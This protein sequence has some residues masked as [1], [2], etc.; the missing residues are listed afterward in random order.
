[1]KKLVILLGITSVGLPIL[2]YILTKKHY[3]KLAKT[4]VEAAINA[5]S[6]EV[7]SFIDNSS[8]KQENQAEEPAEINKED[9]LPI[10]DKK[11]ELTD[12]VSRY[13]KIDYSS[14]FKPGTETQKEKTEDIQPE[15]MPKGS[16]EIRKQI[17]D[18]ELGEL[19]GLNSVETFYFYADGTLTD[20][21]RHII[22]D[23]ENNVGVDALREFHMH[24]VNGSLCIRNYE[25]STD[26]EIL[27]E[28]QE[29]AG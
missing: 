20:S 3:E 24:A 6:A 9:I 13:N 5:F 23:P 17:T 11:P 1:M 28:P 19:W 22:T 18:R 12:Y 27:Y 16:A 29:Y 25:L 10:S 15:E 21:N 26:F 4:E 8:Q 7:K 14:Y 2:T